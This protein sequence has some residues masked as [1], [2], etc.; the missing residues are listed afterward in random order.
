[1]YAQRRSSTGAR[2]LLR[3]GA[4]ARPLL[5]AGA[6]PYSAR[7]LAPTPRGRSPLLRAG[8]QPQREL[9]PLLAAEEPTQRLRGHVEAAV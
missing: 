3:A 4:G 2:P 1:M 8:A 9:A 7:A 6:R 5:R